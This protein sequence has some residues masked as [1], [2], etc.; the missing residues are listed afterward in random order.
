MSTKLMP[1]TPVPALSVDTVGGE[2]FELA[3][4]SSGNFVMIVFYRGHHCPICKTYLQKLD[5][6]VD[7][8]QK[9]R[10]TVIAVSMDG[11]DR[12]RKAVDEWGLAKT[13]IGYGL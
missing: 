6:L 2:R 5:R 4:Q 7:Q 10:F 1:D 13:T 3:A 9:A 8:Y 11:A 12:A